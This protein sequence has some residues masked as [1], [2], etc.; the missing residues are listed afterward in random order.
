MIDEGLDEAKL[1]IRLAGET[2]LERRKYKLKVGHFC[3]G[4]RERD[5]DSEDTLDVYVYINVYQI[6][7]FLKIKMIAASR[8]TLTVQLLL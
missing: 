2:R 4:Q 3:E 1:N 5:S 8:S 6:I 7:I